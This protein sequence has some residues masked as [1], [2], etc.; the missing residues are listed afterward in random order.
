MQCS[1]PCGQVIQAAERAPRTGG[2]ER[3]RG[4]GAWSP[5]LPLLATLLPRGAGLDGQELRPALDDAAGR[6]VPFSSLSA[7]RA[8]RRHSHVHGTLTGCLGLGEGTLGNISV[9][10]APTLGASWSPGS[11]RLWTVAVF[12]AFRGIASAMFWPSESTWPGF[13]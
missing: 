8:H 4:P 12:C 5:A 10:H 11:C 7:P 9:D 6:C 13:V 3:P 1:R 2:W